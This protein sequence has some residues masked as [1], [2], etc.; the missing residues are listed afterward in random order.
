MGDSGMRLPGMRTAKARVA[1]ARS[2]SWRDALVKP[3]SLDPF[4]QLARR[5]RRKP[6]GAAADTARR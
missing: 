6:Y 4:I 5:E 3:D 2:G 1:D